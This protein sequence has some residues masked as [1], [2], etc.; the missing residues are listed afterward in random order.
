MESKG[1]AQATGRGGKKHV[2]KA[3]YVYHLRLIIL[4]SNSSS[5]HRYLEILD[6][7]EMRVFSSDD[8]VI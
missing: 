6:G 2:Y 4:F 1:K 7:E 5:N 8:G 3:W